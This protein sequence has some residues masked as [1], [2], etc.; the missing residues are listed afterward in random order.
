[1]VQVKSDSVVNNTSESRSKLEQVE[2]NASEN[3]LP[4]YFKVTDPAYI[5]LT[6]K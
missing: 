4:A 1:L 2:L 6:Q 5:G 3:P